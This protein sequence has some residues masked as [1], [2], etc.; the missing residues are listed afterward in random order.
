[1]GLSLNKSEISQPATLIND[2]DGYD[3][4]QISEQ[5]VIDVFDNMMA[6]GK[7][8]KSDL[9][10]G[11]IMHILKEHRIHCH[12]H[13]Q[14]PESSIGKSQLE[15]QARKTVFKIINILKTIP[16]CENI[17]V[18]KFSVECGVRESLR[19]DA[20]TNV[21]AEDYINGKVYDDAICYAFYPIDLHTDH[22]IKQQFHNEG[23][24]S[25]VPYTALV[26][27]NTKY[28]LVAGRCLGSDTDANSALRVEAICMATGSA[29]GV[30]AAIMVKYGCENAKVPYCDLCE[31]LK[32]T[33]AIVPE[34]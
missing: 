22:A 3:L 13:T 24:V 10:M 16:G 9:Q 23:V 7:I 19:I 28:I 32:Q 29:A 31:K 4:S 30:A 6:S 5:E 25:T 33:G 12:I 14:N 15:K 21:S 27:K 17:Y 8:T 18:K 1:M 20:V 34:K 11:D 26:P 2:I